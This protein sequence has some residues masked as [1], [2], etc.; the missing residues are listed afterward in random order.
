MDAFFGYLHNSITSRF[1][2]YDSPISNIH[3]N[4]IILQVNQ[5]T[6]LIETFRFLNIF[7]FWKRECESP[8]YH[9]D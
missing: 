1:L 5:D 8:L 3:V 9:V 4:I 7:R 2:V 6:N